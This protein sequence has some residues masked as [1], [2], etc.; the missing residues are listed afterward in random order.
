VERNGD[1]RTI[2]A[3]I[4]GWAKAAHEGNLEAVL[5]H[6]DAARAAHRGFHDP[7]LAGW[8]EIPVRYSPAI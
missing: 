2:R 4:E 3:L 5:A 8:Q 6:H 7:G 1:E